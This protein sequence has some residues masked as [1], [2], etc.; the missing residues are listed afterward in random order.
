[1]DVKYEWKFISV[2]L[3]MQ[4]GAQQ[5]NSL[6]IWDF[7]HTLSAFSTLLFSLVLGACNLFEL[8]CVFFL[9]IWQKGHKHSENKVIFIFDLK[10]MV[11]FVNMIAWGVYCLRWK[12]LSSH[13][14]FNSK[15]FE[16]FDHSEMPVVFALSEIL[17]TTVFKQSVTRKFPQVKLMPF[18]SLC[19]QWVI[20]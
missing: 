15:R 17:K 12:T 20:L 10:L 18:I 1:M 6:L 3:G 4:N 19:V 9:Y 2:L 16:L 8:W 14:S 11:W 13:K 7:Y 5:S